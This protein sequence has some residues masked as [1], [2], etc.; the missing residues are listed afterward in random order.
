MGS[1]YRSVLPSG[2]FCMAFTSCCLENFQASQDGASSM[3][4]N[5][6]LPT[7]PEEARQAAL[8]LRA[9]GLEPPCAHLFQKFA[10]RAEFIQRQSQ[11]EQGARDLL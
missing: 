5:L 7:D 4:R 2:S 1:T 6:T 9:L 11:K 3:K 8:R 10:Q